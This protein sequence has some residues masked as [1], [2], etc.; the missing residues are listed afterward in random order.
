MNR[1]LMRMITTGLFLA[2]FIFSWSCSGKQ[3]NPPANKNSGVSPAAASGPPRFEGY[4][5]VANCDGV[6]GWV[7]DQNQPNNPVTVEIYEGTKVLATMDADQLRENLVD[8]GK[9]D[10]KHAYTYI[11]PPYLKDGKPHAIQVRVAGAGYELGNS[12]KTI[13]CTFQSEDKDKK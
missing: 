5:D 2:I 3:E 12:P 1:Y 8:A 11:L 10:G 9:G 4:L 13:T 7:W 6:H